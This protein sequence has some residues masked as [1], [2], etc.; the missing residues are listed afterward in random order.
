VTDPLQF[1]FNF[2]AIAM[3]FVMIKLKLVGFL[4]NVF[5]M[6]NMLQMINGAIRTFSHPD[7]GLLKASQLKMPL[8]FYIH[9]QQTDR[10]SMPI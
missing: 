10:H 1:V 5:C 3:P 8:L 6:T 7:D 2:L 9:V 4:V